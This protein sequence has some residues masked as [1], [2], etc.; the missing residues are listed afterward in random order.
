MIAES[1]EPSCRSTDRLKAALAPEQGGSTLATTDGR[2]IFTFT[3]NLQPTFQARIQK[4][5][6]TAN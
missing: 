1:K 2:F 5:K 4:L 6:R 3:G